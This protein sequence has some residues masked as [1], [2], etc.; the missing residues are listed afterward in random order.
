MP[1]TRSYAL[2]AAAI[3]LAGTTAAAWF[4]LQPSND[5]LAECGGGI[6]T[7]AAQIGGPFELV[8]HT[9]E[10]IT[11]VELIDKP[12]LVYFGYTFCPDVCPIDAAAMA[13]TRAILEEGGR[14]IGTAF[15]TIDPARDTVE[16]LSDFVYNLDPKMVALTGSDEQIAAAA[17]AY[18]VYYQ[19]ADTDDPE[20]Y[21][22]DHSAFTYLMAPGHGFLDI[23]RHGDPP[24]AMAKTT[25]C[26]VDALAG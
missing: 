22:M 16:A 13:Q 5:V 9:G 3:A 11:D 24:E 21:L 18:R 1:T 14:S 2:A 26:Y 8:A 20:F 15:I 10:S 6:A 19:K 17:K 4:L 25:A 7:G 23:F 12:T